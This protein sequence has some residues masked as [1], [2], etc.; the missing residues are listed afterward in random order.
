VIILT[1]LISFFFLESKV[2][3]FV[4]PFSILEMYYVMK[5]V[6]VSSEFGVNVK[7]MN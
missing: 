1:F 4:L 2:S 7:Q 3:L 5:L 6:V